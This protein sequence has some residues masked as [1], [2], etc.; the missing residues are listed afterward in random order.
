MGAHG[1]P[2]AGAWCNSRILA[3]D[4]RRLAGV[5]LATASE[6]RASQDD[7]TKSGSSPKKFAELEST[8]PQG[9]SPGSQNAFC[10][11]GQQSG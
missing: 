11:V 5:E 9:I 7:G 2:G 1:K 8:E 6:P 4:N 10:D 3:G